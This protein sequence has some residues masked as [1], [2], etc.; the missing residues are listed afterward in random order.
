MQW[1]PSQDLFHICRAHHVICIGL[2]FHV[3]NPVSVFHSNF[4]HQGPTHHID[5]GRDFVQFSIFALTWNDGDL[6]CLKFQESRKI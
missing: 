3:R 6:W 2:V 4:V 5:G 1:S